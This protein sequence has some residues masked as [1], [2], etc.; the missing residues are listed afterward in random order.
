MEDLPTIPHGLRLQPDFITPAH[1]AQ[2]LHIFQHELEWPEAKKPGTRLSLHYGYTFDYKTFGIDPDIPYRPFPD[3]LRP[4]IPY[5]GGEGQG[6]VDGELDEEGRDKRKGRDPD[7]VCLQ[8]YPPGAGIPP[9]VDTHSAYDELFALS[10]GSPVIMRFRRT[11]D[12]PSPTPSPSPPSATTTKDKDTVMAEPKPEKEAP[13]RE[14]VDIDLPPRSMMQMSGDARLHWEHGIAKRKKDVLAD[15]TTVRA[16]GDRWS[17][18]Y[19]W[20]RAGGVCE[21]GNER[22]CDT[23]Q[24]RRGVEREYRWKVGKKAD[25]EEEQG[26]QGREGKANAGTTVKGDNDGVGSKPAEI[27]TGSTELERC[28]QDEHANIIPSSA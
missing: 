5:V 9:H 10:L 13:E 6:E 15:G 7:Q 3:W 22:L 26:G 21:C 2:L 1:E 28:L 8:H 19:R 24:M 12:P 14:F 11:R 17:I 20:L 23:A 25:G 18:T 16:R 4:L 27:P